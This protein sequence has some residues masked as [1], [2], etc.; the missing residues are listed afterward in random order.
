MNKKE[1]DNRTKKILLLVL[2]CIAIV[3][4]VAWIIISLSPK[5]TPILICIIA[6]LVGFIALQFV[7]IVTNR[8]KGDNKKT[9][10]I[11]GI[12]IVVLLIQRVF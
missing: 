3:I 6:M 10:L 7:L 5:P 8:L 1:L 11:F 12:A 9:L 2:G 4:N